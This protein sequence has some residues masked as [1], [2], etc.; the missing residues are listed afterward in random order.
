MA[1]NL[2]LTP[3]AAELIHRYIMAD[4]TDRT[5]KIINAAG[6]GKA[7]KDTNEF[8]HEFDRAAKLV[9]YIVVWKRDGDRKDEPVKVEL[10]PKLKDMLGK[11][12]HTLLLV[13]RKSNALPD[14][15]VG[16]VNA[17]GVFVSTQPSWK[18]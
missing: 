14:D 7:Y 10:N 5:W 15:F 9:N 2:E 8:E 1:T 4:L 12:I 11:M 18:K 3:A 16:E 17:G 13:L 6:L